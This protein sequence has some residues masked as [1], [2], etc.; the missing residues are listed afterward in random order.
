MTD[1]IERTETPQPEPAYALADLLGVPVPELGAGLPPLW[2]WVYLLDRPAQ[3]DLG[4][5]GHPVRGTLP[6]PPGPGRRRMWAGGRV[7]TS[8]SLRCGRPA[9]RRTR[10]IA[11]TEKHGRSGHLTFVTVGHQVAQ[12]GAVVVDEE[13]DI[14][15]RDADGPPASAQAVPPVVPAGQG[16]REIGISPALLF[17]FS[18]L[19]YNAHRIHYDRDYCRD[20]EGYPG[21]LTHGPLQALAMAEA[22]RTAGNTGGSTGGRAG[23]VSFEYRLVSPLF[24]DQGLI[25]SAAPGPDGTTV[26]AA[27]DRY[28]RQTAT[29]TFT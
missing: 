17:R 2:H 15:Y 4:P 3:A 20:V 9:T 6:A 1:V 21:L 19:T 26:T 12:D 7:R 24:D 16:E 14:V 23:D 27:R 18:A 29:G 11:V 5:D 10:V 28:G 25:V 22:A 13:Q 8:G